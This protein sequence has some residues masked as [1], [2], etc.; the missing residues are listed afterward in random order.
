M[1]AAI[2]DGVYDA[3]LAAEQR[4]RAL[5]E[6]DLDDLSLAQFPVDLHRIPVARI[7]PR[8]A[9]LLVQIDG[10]LEIG[11]SAVLRGERTAHR[12]AVHRGAKRPRPDRSTL[13]R[14]P[15]KSQTRAP[16][17]AHRALATATPSPPRSS[18]GDPYI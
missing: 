18:P 10:V 2:L 14:A 17:A 4:E 8:R 1:N 15:P 11:R 5:P 16:R 6:G 12:R 13:R 3:V 9:H 7:E